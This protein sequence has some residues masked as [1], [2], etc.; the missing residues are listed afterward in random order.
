MKYHPPHLPTLAILVLGGCLAA[1]YTG[2][3]EQRTAQAPTS[4]ATPVAGS[5]S[6]ALGPTSNGSEAVTNDNPSTI[7]GFSRGDL[8]HTANG[9]EAVTNDNESASFGHAMGDLPFTSNDN[10]AETNDNPSI[11][12]SPAAGVRLSV[13]PTA[14]P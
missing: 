9:S 11:G 8:E 10:E 2:C 14:H 3:S 12:F 5:T 1:C 4:S 13:N 6:K 7:F